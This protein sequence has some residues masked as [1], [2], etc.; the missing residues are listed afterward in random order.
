MSA[1][2]R[3]RLAARIATQYQ[4][5]GHR[6]IFVPDLN[7]VAAVGNEAAAN[8]TNAVNSA[9][10]AAASLAAALAI[11]GGAQGVGADPLDV[12]RGAEL[13][14]AAFMDAAIL[15]GVFVLTR[16]ADYQIL[17]QDWGA[18]IRATSG[19]RTWTLPAASA[20]PQGWFLRIKNRSGSNLTIART[21]SDTIDGAAASLVVATGAA[22]II[23]RAGSGDWESA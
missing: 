10:Q 7:D 2:A 1:A 14:S 13:G 18:L 21:G 9:A 23:A 19:T 8:G 11:I 22:R 4:N 12:P 3:A 16:D 20:V 15:R 5:G 6:S 17:P